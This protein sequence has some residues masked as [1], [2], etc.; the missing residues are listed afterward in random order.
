[1]IA[2]EE[3][4]LLYTHDVEKLDR[5]DNNAVTCLFS[6]ETLYHISTHHPEYIREIV[7]LFLFVLS[8]GRS[9]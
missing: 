7:Y 2:I 3:D 4:S 1:E 8:S 9:K 6:S 5:Q